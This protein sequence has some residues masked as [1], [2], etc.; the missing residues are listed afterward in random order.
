MLWHRLGMARFILRK[1]P[2]GVTLQREGEAG[3]QPIIAK[4]G[5]PAVTVVGSPGELTLWVAGRKTAA[6]VRFD[7]DE[8]CVAQLGQARWGL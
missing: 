6:Q 5:T 4:R 8:E 1:A 7:G 2:C 3:V